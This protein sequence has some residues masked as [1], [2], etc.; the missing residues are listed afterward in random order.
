[1]RL[2]WISKIKCIEPHVLW[3]SF[4][5]SQKHRRLGLKHITPRVMVLLFL[6]NPTS[7]RPNLRTW[8]DSVG[9][10]AVPRRHV[11]CAPPCTPQCGTT[12]DQRC[13]GYVPQT[14]MHV[15]FCSYDLVTVGSGF[16]VKILST[17]IVL[18]F[19]GHKTRVWTF[20]FLITFLVSH[21][22]K[23]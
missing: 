13:W 9:Q 20:F 14:R 7:R 19:P 10:S 18:Q 6:P 15:L 23:L 3:L 1:M 4:I 22:T 17:I 2:P 21:I 8:P 12:G 5:F 11:A 16:F